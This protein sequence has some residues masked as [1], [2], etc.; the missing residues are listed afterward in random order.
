[1]IRAFLTSIAF[2]ITLHSTAALAAVPL[3]FDC[4]VPADHFS[5]VTQDLE[6]P[7]VSLQGVV[8]VREMRSGNNLPVAGA[9]I[10]DRNTKNMLGFQLVAASP[11]AD[12]FA[13]V[14][15][16]QVEGKLQKF[17]VGQVPAK[18]A[19]SFQLTV[20][21]SGKGSFI[22]DGK[23]ADFEFPPLSGS[24]AMVFCSTGQF[25]FSELLFQDGTSGQAPSKP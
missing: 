3:A 19:I 15:N 18:A 4:D 2:G 16:K 6:Q 23:E 11:K 24:K 14:L 17:G 12:F 5:S 13:V 9:R 21:G 25:K 1:M 7:S 8:Q 20:D 10:A 22:V